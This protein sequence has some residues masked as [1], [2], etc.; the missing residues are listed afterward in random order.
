MRTAAAWGALLAA[1]RLSLVPGQAAAQDAA[2]QPEGVPFSVKDVLKLAE[3]LAGKDFERPTVEAA[4]PFNA[5]TAEQYRDIRF[6]PEQALWQPERLGVEAHL[7]PRGWIYETPV[8][9]HVVEGGKARRLVADSRLFAFGQK[10]ER[11]PEEAPY[12]FSGFRLQGPI[13][14]G[15]E[16]DAFAIFQGASYFRAR[17]RDETF[18]LSARGLA[19]NTAQ[20]TGEEFPIFRAF[21]IEKPK[22]AGGD[23]VVH[24]LL[25]SKSVAG[26]YRFV[27]R[28]GSVT[29]ID[30]DAVLYLRRSL[31]HIGLAP[32]TSMFLKGPAHR[33]INND[34]RPSVHNSQGLA[35]LN[36]RGERLWRPLTNPRTLQT[37][38][39]VDKNPRGFGLIQRDRRLSSFEDLGARFDKRPSLWVEPRGA[40]GKGFVELVEIPSE[41]EIHDN[42]V[43]YWNPAEPLEPGKAHSL[44]YRL[45][46]GEDMPVAPAPSRV[47]QTAV[48]PMRKEGRHQFAVDFAG[49]AVSETRDMPV[50]DLSA[51]AGTLSGAVVERHAGIG[52]VRVT[53]TL[54]TG[55]AD[56]S[57]LRL[58][59]KRGEQYISETWLYRWTA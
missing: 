30:V 1:S 50:A 25:D 41:E 24:A 12:A 9:I 11:A 14:R 57:E 19:I 38:A 44:S 3:D 7:L 23:I 40:W 5:L 28:Q 6:R 22:T 13:D 54:D 43:V 29:H 46:W 33:R 15:D 35:I 26:A 16:L 42:I 58:S 4:E 37:S 53:F 32:L 27:I 36:G 52:G 39:F 49:P 51:S 56:M 59:L 20:P 45:T 21:W 18:G 2:A 10:I 55:G 17:G 31:K 8:D 34:I 48:G 47:M